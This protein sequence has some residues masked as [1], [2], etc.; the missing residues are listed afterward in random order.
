MDIGIS[1]SF[2]YIKS[3]LSI[4]QEVILAPGFASDLQA[5]KTRQLLDKPQFTARSL[6]IDS[7]NLKYAV[8]HTAISH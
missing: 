8:L 3:L 5:Y 7:V 4:K 2:F 6:K 1:D